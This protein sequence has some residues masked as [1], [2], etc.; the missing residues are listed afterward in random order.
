MSCDGSRSRRAALAGGAGLAIVLL[1]SPVYSGA[2]QESHA[3]ERAVIDVAGDV[4]PESTWLGPL[5]APHIFDGVRDEFARADLVFVNV[6]EPITSSRTVTRGKNPASV[7]AGRDYVL[8][9][10]NTAIPGILK[11]AGV[12]LAG[13]AN[14]HMMDYTSVGL[15]DTLRIFEQAELPVVGAGLKPDAERAFVFKT[16]GFRVALLAF[17][18]VVPTGSAAT[19]TREGVASSQDEDDLIRAIQRARQQADFVVL[20]I[21]WGGQGG[22]LI[23]RRQ[24]QLGRLI[25]GAGCDAVVGMHPHVLQGVEFA[26]RTPVFY[27]VGNFAFPSSRADARESVVVR[28][29]FG[30]NGLEKEEVVPAEISPLGAPSVAAGPAGEAILGH[31]D[32]YCRM[33][34]SHIDRGAVV[35]GPARQEL[36]YDTSGDGR[37]RKS[38]KRHV[39]RSHA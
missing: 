35:R 10:R 25:A 23:T 33:F 13:L 30:A 26:G 37:A 38:S 15:R 18:D 2:A 27:S 21:H 9:A 24:R 32:R 31:L 4:L 39:N 34:N 22:H 12:G 28:L 16:H 7:R 5:D 6:E 20:M 17:T 1:T 29:T 8:R 14:N 36:V 19:E 11:A 3:S